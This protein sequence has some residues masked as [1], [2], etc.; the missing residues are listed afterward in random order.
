MEEKNKTGKQLL[1][2]YSSLAFQLLASVGLAVYIGLAIDKWIKISI[3]LFVWLL[4]L[5]VIIAMIIKAI[6][7]TSNK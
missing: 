4:P 1:W 3:P 6:R 7:D 2:Q 5:I